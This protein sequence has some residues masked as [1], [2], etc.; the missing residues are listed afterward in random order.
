MDGDNNDD[1]DDER[2]EFGDDFDDGV[3]FDD[4]LNDIKNYRKVRSHSHFTEKYR[5]AAHSICNLRYKTPKE[6]TV[7]LHNGSSY[8]LHFIIKE[9]Q[10]W[11]K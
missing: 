4:E 11:T 5:E 2:F 1:H 8:D 10:P 6:I 7:V 3:G 9:L